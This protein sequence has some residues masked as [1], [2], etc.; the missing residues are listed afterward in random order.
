MFFKKEVA[1]FLLFSFPITLFV[2]GFFISSR[3]P[4]AVRRRIP[5]CY[6]RPKIP[7][8]G[9]PHAGRV[10]KSHHTDLAYIHSRERAYG[11][12]RIAAAL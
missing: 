8:H 5:D 11:I 9:W 2:S 3:T 7:M 10:Y 4:Q 1:A 12:I 6:A